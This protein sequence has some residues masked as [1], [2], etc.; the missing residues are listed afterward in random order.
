MAD[1]PPHEKSDATSELPTLRRF[2]TQAVTLAAIM[3]SSLGCYLLVLYWRGK[4]AQLVTHIAWDD[5]VPFQPAWV[6]AYLIPYLIGP[7]VIGLMTPATF[8]WYVKR[9]LVVVGLTLSFFILVPTKTQE[10]PET[11]L[12][13]GPT[14]KLYQQ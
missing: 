1:L 6:W 5:V 7:I 14:A 12:G 13:D 8:G 11:H 4:D 3:M 10:R 9:G 2:L